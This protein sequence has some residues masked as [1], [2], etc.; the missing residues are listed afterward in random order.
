[1]SIGGHQGHALEGGAKSGRTAISI[2]EIPSPAPNHKENGIFADNQ[3]MEPPNS[4]VP[5][6]AETTPRVVLKTALFAQ[7]G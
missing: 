4:T 5:N 6:A 2:P 7:W 3:N 1:M